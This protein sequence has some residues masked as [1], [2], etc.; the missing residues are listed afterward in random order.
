MLRITRVALSIGAMEPLDYAPPAGPLR[1][2][3]RDT[4][5]L[6]IDKPPGILSVP[7]KRPGMRDCVIAR[8]GQ[9][10]PGTLLVHRLDMATSGV[11]VFALTRMAQRHIGRQF[12][13]R[14]PR[15]TYLARIAGHLQPET[16]RVDQPLIAD[17]ENRPRQKTCHETGREALTDWRVI[18]RF[19]EGPDAE[20]LLA[21][22]PETGRSHQLRVHMQW[23]GHP[24][25]GDRL[26]AEGAT[27]DAWPRMM[28]HAETLAL[29]H[30]DGGAWVEFHAPAPFVIG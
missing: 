30:P 3:H 18:R 15:K 8:L 26:Y 2:L 28:L 24:I 25:L 12:E 11:M 7:G 5:L 10:V 29:R 20:T 23:L 21:L 17:W 19:G 13:S 1:I 6:V 27:R 16:G 9:M 22:M 4:H 14:I